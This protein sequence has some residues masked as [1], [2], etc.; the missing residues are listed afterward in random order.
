MRQT[1][2]SIYG[3]KVFQDGADIVVINSRGT[4]RRYP[5][6]TIRESRAKWDIDSH[7]FPVS[8]AAGACAWGW[9]RPV[10]AIR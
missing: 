9:F 2:Y 3:E 1:H 4:E 7:M 10:E 5:E 8:H 6:S